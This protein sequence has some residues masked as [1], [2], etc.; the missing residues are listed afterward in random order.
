LETFCGEAA[1][2]VLKAKNGGLTL[3]NVDLK[4]KALFYKESDD[5][6]E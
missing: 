5:Y 3:I 2:I 6:A 1:F 4:A